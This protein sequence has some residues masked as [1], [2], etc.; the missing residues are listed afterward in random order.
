MLV[1]THV[2]NATTRQAGM[3]IV[4]QDGKPIGLLTRVANSKTETH[5][6]K[7]YWGTGE[8]ASYLGAFYTNEGGKRAA[9]AAIERKARAMRYQDPTAW[10]PVARAIDYPACL[11][12]ASQVVCRHRTFKR[13]KKCKRAGHVGAVLKD[14]SV[15]GI[16]LKYIGASNGE[17]A[18][19]PYAAT[20]ADYQKA[21]NVKDTRTH[22]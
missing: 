19:L 6:W 15:I 22:A 8:S 14:G 5:P 13:V 17:T 7:V 18:L 21:L 20:E 10:I 2:R 3:W 1:V 12:E 9:V 11:D 4:H 16:H